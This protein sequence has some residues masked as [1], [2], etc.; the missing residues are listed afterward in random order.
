MLCNQRYNGW[1]L[2]IVNMQKQNDDILY[3]QNYSKGYI[4][5]G[6]TSKI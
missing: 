4:L 5:Y 3:G 2:G 6:K 1:R